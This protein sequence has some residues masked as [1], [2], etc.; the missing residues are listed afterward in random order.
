MYPADIAGMVLIDSAHEDEPQRAPKFFLADTAPAYLRHPLYLMM[1]ATG[2]AGALRFM[3]RRPQLPARPTKQQVI[4]ALRQQPK[5]LV[6]DISTGLMVPESYREAHDLARM[7]S[8][9]LI[10]LTAGKPQRWNNPE[11][12]RQ[13]A[14]Y[15]QVW[16]HEMQSQLTRLSSRGRQI[17]VENSD[18]GIPDEAPEVVVSA[19]QE[20]VTAA[21]VE[22]Q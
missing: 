7:G 14:A 21:R 6:T 8:A 12:A 19:I 13:A 18:H 17:V 20:V 3:Q 10:V 11:M 9:P 1:K 22:S 4:G 2:W 15:Q 16:I 5:S